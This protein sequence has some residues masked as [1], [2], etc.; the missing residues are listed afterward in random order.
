MAV[1]K[2]TVT[3]GGNFDRDFSGA[4]AIQF[5]KQ[6]EAQ[7]R[8][9]AAWDDQNLYLAWDVRDK[10]P[11]I[12]KAAMPEQ[13]YVGGD[14]VDFQ[15]GVDPRADKNREEA[16]K[17]DLRLSIGNF[18]GR[19]TAVIYRRVSDLKKPKQFSSGVVKTYP[20]DFVDVVAAARIKVGV[21]PNDGYLVEAA[22][23]LSV[24]GLRPR[25]GLNLAG[26]FGVTHGGPDGGRTRLRTYWN[27]QHTGIVDDAVFELRMEPKNWGLLEFKP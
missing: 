7:V 8:A 26:D 12:N 27:N 11:W 10:T 24:L 1:R 18:K 14:T 19:P 9:A 20:M 15:L 6:E 21:R 3:L 23:P 5:K 4:D 25:A 13:M 16:A 2:K 17:G 22:I